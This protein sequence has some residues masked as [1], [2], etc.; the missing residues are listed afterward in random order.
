MPLLTF[1]QKTERGRE[2]SGDIF[3]RPSCDRQ[4]A[5]SLW[6]VG[7]ETANYRVSA[8]P[9]R[10]RS[11]S[12]VAS[13]LGWISQK[14]EHR[15]VMPEVKAAG[16]QHRVQDIRDDPVHFSCSITE[17]FSSHGQ[18]FIR[19]I[20][21]AE[22]TDTTIEQI[23]HERRGSA[24]NINDSRIRRQAG[25]FQQLD[26]HVQMRPIPADGL[27]CLCSIDF[28]PVWLPVDGLRSHGGNPIFFTIAAKRGSE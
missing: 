5:A 7:R 22:V 21:N 23:I 27:G 1:L 10:F 28:L 15:P 11:A 19:D 6:A 9:Y 16:R 24:A 2:Y 8:D 13:G 26:G 4:S 14:V 20:Q 17:S 12:R 25:Q 3:C 18:G